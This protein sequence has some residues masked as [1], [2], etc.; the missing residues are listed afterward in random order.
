M[1]ALNLIPF[2]RLESRRRRSLRRGWVVGCACYGA[3]V[4]AAGAAA[5]A[6]DTHSGS[7]LQARLQ[8]AGT[9]V[10]RASAEV[11]GFRTELD[12][13][14]SLLRS[15]RAIAEQ[16]D[17]SSLL[18]LMATKA[19]QDVTLKGCSVRPRQVPSPT[20]GVPKPASPSSPKSVKPAAI[21]PTLLVNVAGLGASQAAV[22]QF[23]LR[24]EG[25]GLFGRVTLLDTTREP[26]AD[27]QLVSFRIECTL[28]EPGKPAAARPTDSTANIAGG[29][30]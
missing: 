6:I 17:W 12:R 23:A 13:V 16:P 24:L 22:S 25:T 15:S 19:G 21:D 7:D 1:Q 26:F 5:L 9:E 20:A 27:K 29:D 3:L 4:A 14:Q 10:D 18:A 28:A 2:H 11:A 30:R 8:T